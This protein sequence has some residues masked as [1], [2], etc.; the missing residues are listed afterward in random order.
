[1]TRA[2]RVVH[3]NKIPG[4]DRPWIR[5]A[6]L[7]ERALMVGSPMH[8]FG[9]SMWPEWTRPRRS[10]MDVGL[11]AMIIMLLP[12]QMNFGP[13]E[14]QSPRRSWWCLSLMERA[15]TTRSLAD[16]LEATSGR[17]KFGFDAR[18]C[19]ATNV[20]WLCIRHSLEKPGSMLRSWTWTSWA[21]SMECLIFWSGSKQ[22]SWRWR[23]PKAPR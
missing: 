5:G 15:P 7:H 14:I 3:G 20:P 11:E 19:Q 9:T 10:T 22:G 8:S 21:A 18:R 6:E 4:H 1:M 23:C 2:G 16:R 12:G 13:R 17:C